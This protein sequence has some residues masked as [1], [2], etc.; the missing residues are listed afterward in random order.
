[1][2]DSQLALAFQPYLRPGE[3]IVWAGRPGG[4]IVFAPSDVFAVPFSFL[5]AGIVVFNFGVDGFRGGGGFPFGLF[6]IVFVAAGAYFTVGRFI[7][8]TWG[9]SRMAYAL[10]DQRA[11]VLRR[12]MSETLLTA[13]LDSI[14][15]RRARDGRGTIDF[16]RK[17]AA[18]WSGWNRNLSSWT[19][20]LSNQ[21]RFVQIADVMEVYALA[22]RYGGTRPA[23]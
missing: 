8:D 12:L 3:R 2:V 20:S 15:L 6:E 11:L 10:T 7:H 17:Y 18:A 22:Q 4:G 1:V 5:W 16:D 23:P 9:R 19:P 21:V 13:Q 14:S